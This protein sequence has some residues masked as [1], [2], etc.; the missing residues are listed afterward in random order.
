MI[1]FV[2]FFKRLFVDF[3]CFCRWRI[4]FNFDFINFC[5]CFDFCFWIDNCDLRCVVRICFWCKVLLSFFFNFLI[6]LRDLV[7]MFL[8]VKFFWDNLI[9]RSCMLCI[10]CFFFI[11]CFVILDFLF[12]WLFVCL[13]FWFGDRVKLVGIDVFKLSLFDFILLNVL[14]KFIVV[15]FVNFKLLFI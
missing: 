8:R 14:D 4:F 1:F 11:N 15:I 7:F 3:N 6:L 5:C 9:F 10:N 2:F 12:L 13:F